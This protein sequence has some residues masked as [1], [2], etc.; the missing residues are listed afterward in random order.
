MFVSGYVPVWVYI[1]YICWHLFSP[2]SKVEKT[3][4]S[5]LTRWRMESN[6]GL[7]LKKG[8]WVSLCLGHRAVGLICN[9]V[10]FKSSQSPRL[11][12][13]EHKMSLEIVSGF[14]ASL[15]FNWAQVCACV[16][17]MCMRALWVWLCEPSPLTWTKCTH[18]YKVQTSL[19]WYFVYACAIF[20]NTY[21]YTMRV[22]TPA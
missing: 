19:F 14:E 2:R 18:F 5:T 17:C 1:V 12:F 7:Y 21:A 22:H 20:L 6:Q 10:T 4:S 9:S 13:L 3:S 11:H 8:M 15:D 16:W